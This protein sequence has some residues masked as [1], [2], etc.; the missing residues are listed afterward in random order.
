MLEGGKG[1]EGKHSWKTHPIT[2]CLCEEAYVQ[3]W[4]TG[5]PT[6]QQLFQTWTM[7][8]GG[9]KKKSYTQ[10]I[11]KNIL[12]LSWKILCSMFDIPNSLVFMKEIIKCKWIKLCS[13]NVLTFTEKFLFVHREWLCIKKQQKIDWLVLDQDSPSWLD[14]G[15]PRARGDLTLVMSSQQQ[16]GREAVLLE[17][18][19]PCDPGHLCCKWQCW[20]KINQHPF[21]FSFVTAFILQFSKGF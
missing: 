6:S 12:P 7:I 4:D 10:R 11:R 20:R 15:K 1:G 14:K 19:L 18:K 17:R 3:I 5:G 8:E 21:S 16:Q 13:D 9:R 2:V